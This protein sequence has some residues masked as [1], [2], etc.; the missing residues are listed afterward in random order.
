MSDAPPSSQTDA[1][2]VDGTIT[3][4]TGSWYDVR[5]DDGSVIS[6]RVRGKFR[7][8]ETAA[9]NPVA[10]GDRV[11]VRLD[12][13]DTG[14]ITEIH[15]RQNQLSRRAAGRRVG[16]EHVLVAN[17]DH[18]WIVQAV[19]LPEPNPGFIDRVLVTAE[20]WDLPAGLVFNKQDLL[21]DEDSSVKSM[22]TCYE[23]IG[24]P[25]LR[26]SAKTG[27]G[28]DA[29]R[30]QLTD[31]TSVVTGPSGVGKSSLLNQVDPDLDLRT[32]EVS[33][34]TRKGQHVTTHAALHPLPDGGFV[35]DT[36]GLRE[37]GLMDL[38]PADLAHYYVEFVPYVNECRFPDCT[39][40]HEP[41][42]AVKDAVERGDLST[43]RYESYLKILHSLQEDENRT[44]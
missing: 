28:V 25:V 24:Y 9:T 43:M 27:T 29:F 2:Y 19:R 10:V 44:F 36:P 39:H 1:E 8:S 4:S 33:S 40:D 23:E 26:T 5:T 21:A 7:L 38:A 35:A 14:L 18:V 15:P 37:F 41:G 22:M 6:A 11:T 31:Q 3:R 30:E 42:C 12:E 16:E 17:I 13:D 32:G 34:R 20:L